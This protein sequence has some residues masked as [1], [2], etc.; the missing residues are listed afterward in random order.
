M[1]SH[2]QKKEEHLHNHRNPFHCILPPHV[3]DNIIEKGSAQ[4][5]VVDLEKRLEETVG[6]IEEC[7][8]EQAI[9]EHDQRGIILKIEDIEKMQ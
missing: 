8:R 7:K 6:N 3:V 2:S 1:D 4:Q 9:N 5:K